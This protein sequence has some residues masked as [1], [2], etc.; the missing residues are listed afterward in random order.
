MIRSLRCSSSL[1]T[2]TDF[3]IWSI[4]SLEILPK[5]NTSRPPPLF[6]I[7]N[8]FQDTAETSG[9]CA[10]GSMY[11]RSLTAWND[12]W[13]ATVTWHCDSS[14]LHIYISLP[15]SRL[16]YRTVFQTTRHAYCQYE[17]IRVRLD[18]P[19]IPL[20]RHNDCVNVFFLKGYSSRELGRK[21]TI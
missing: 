3:L 16:I 5:R 6:L 10:L 18:V 1:T 19:W 8:T 15:S 21:I 14:S 9:T 13:H 7:I 4:H 12:I 11:S 2:A 20:L 17:N